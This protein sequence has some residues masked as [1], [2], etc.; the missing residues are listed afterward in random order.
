MNCYSAEKS[1]LREQSQVN[2]AG[3][4]NKAEDLSLTKEAVSVTLSDDRASGEVK[5]NAYRWC[6]QCLRG[7]WGKI[8]VDEFEIEHIRCV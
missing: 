8:S 2:M 6:K 5:S 4:R 3:L 1:T 7:S